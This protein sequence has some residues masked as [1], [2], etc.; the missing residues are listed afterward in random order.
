[1]SVI[2]I[3]LWAAT[4]LLKVFSEWRLKRLFVLCFSFIGKVAKNI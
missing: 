4:A 1:M 2:A 3:L